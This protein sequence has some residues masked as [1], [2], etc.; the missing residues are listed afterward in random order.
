MP[1]SLTEFAMRIPTPLFAWVLMLA[2]PVSA[3]DLPRTPAPAGAEVYFIS[4]AD[5][6]VVKGEVDVRFGLRGMG[7]APAG[8]QLADTGHHHLLIDAPLPPAG[9]PIPKDERHLHFGGGQT[10]ATLSL[11]PGTHT[12][13]LLVGDHSHVSLD[14]VVASEVITITVEE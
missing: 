6:D 10:E 4:P 9:Q 14:P 7:V 8:I 5:G 13:Q 2:L 11:A 12:L 3:A 1:W